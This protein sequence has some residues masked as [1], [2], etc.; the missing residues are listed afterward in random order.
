MRT[1]KIFE[2]LRIFYKAAGTEQT[3]SFL[4]GTDRIGSERAFQQAEDE[5]LVVVTPAKNQLFVDIDGPLQYATY[6]RNR[7]VL[8]EFYEVTGS[9]ENPSKSGDEF[10]CH[11]TISLAEDIDDRERLLL[12]A[13]L[14]SD[15]KREFLG[16]QRVKIQDPVPTLFLEKKPEKLGIEPP[17]VT[18][19]TDDIPF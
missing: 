14:G 11:I 1:D 4:G 18:D 8:E 16:L 19:F 6:E 17:Y 10:R 5:N 9:S 13:F 15:L 2:V 3:G 12:Q 7:P